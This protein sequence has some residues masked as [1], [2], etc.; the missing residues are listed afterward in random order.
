MA[1]ANEDGGLS[2][3][4]RLLDWVRGGRRTVR[5]TFLSEESRRPEALDEDV[6]VD[7]LLAIHGDRTARGQEA[8]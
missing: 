3:T 5:G 2:P 8:V 7:G 1:A 4:L 6:S